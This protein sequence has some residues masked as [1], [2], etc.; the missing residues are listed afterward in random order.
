MTLTFQEILNLD[1]RR[2]TNRVSA[3][4]M[5][6]SQDVDSEMANFEKELNADLNALSTQGGQNAIEYN[7]ITQCGFMTKKLTPQENKQRK[8]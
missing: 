3:Y 7:E 8:F 5:G 4:A 6:Q 1:R 2:Y